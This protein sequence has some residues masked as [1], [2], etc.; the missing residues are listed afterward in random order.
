MGNFPYPEP[1]PVS[2]GRRFG[3]AGISYLNF[4]VFMIK[5]GSGLIIFGTIN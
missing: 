2:F 1:F 3:S 5:L 4:L